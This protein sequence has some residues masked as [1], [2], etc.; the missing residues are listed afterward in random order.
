MVP[1]STLN[2][3]DLSA[4]DS[5]QDGAGE[6]KHEEKEWVGLYACTEARFLTHRLPPGLAGTEGSS[7]PVCIPFFPS[8]SLGLYKS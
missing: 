4:S 7:S 8:S 5:A 6:R 2:V 1:Q 3:L